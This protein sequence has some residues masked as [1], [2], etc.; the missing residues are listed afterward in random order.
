VIYRDA[1][2]DVRFLEIN[3]ATY[4]LL[5]LMEENRSRRAR[6]ILAQIASELHHPDPSAVL[7]FGT[8]TLRE[9]AERGIIGA[10]FLDP[11]SA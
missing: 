10:N 5:Q 2:D 6:E 4:R 1:D 7:D 11:S 9:L 8:N 3:S